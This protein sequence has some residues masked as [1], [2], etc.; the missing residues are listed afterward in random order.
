MDLLTNSHG[1]S[2]IALK[3]FKY[4]RQEDVFNCRKVC[5][6]WKSLIDSD[7]FWLRLHI[8]N[9]YQ[10]IQKSQV[11]TKY[12]YLP[13][14]RNVQGKP[15]SVMKIYPD[16]KGLFEEALNQN[17]K[18]TEELIPQLKYYYKN[19]AV[20]MQ[21]FQHPV[22]YAAQNGDM[23]LLK[24]LQDHCQADCNV[25]D[26]LRKCIPIHIACHYSHLHMVEYLLEHWTHLTN[27]AYF[28]STFI[29]ACEQHN[30]QIL[31]KLVEYAMDKHI[32]IDA[33]NI[34]GQKA[35]HAT[36]NARYIHHAELL[37]EYT[38]ELGLDVNE[39]D[40]S[41]HENTAFHYACSGP[42]ELVKL[43]VN[44]AERRGIDLNATNAFN[45][46][47]F[48]VACQEG[49]LEVVNY[50]LSQAS[51]LNIDLN[52]VDDGGKTAFMYACQAI[53]KVQKVNAFIKHSKHIQID[54]RQH[55][56][57][58]GSMSQEDLPMLIILLHN[59]KALNINVNAIDNAGDTHLHWTLKHLYDSCIDNVDATACLFLYHPDIDLNIRNND[60]KTPLDLAKRAGNNTLIDLINQRQQ[61]KELE[62]EIEGPS[63]AK[64][65]KLN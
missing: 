13:N 52:V 4:L 39:T 49:S 35:L 36:T 33:R 10:G 61:E 31:E 44:Q 56:V 27:K 18:V 9:I 25:K 32:R 1:L 53:D 37:L 26:K 59:S 23:V 63:I 48:I 60:G 40:L 2:W 34:N 38:Q 30:L 16:L 7:I 45:R 50:L 64:L 5:K 20:G 62:I 14:H 11:Y 8:A 46:T 47:G 15:E 17:R 28:K 57:L 58:S 6:L 65:P 54:N 24:L 55:K 43:F 22:H 51:A 12:M 3:I 21:R 41:E 19:T 29:I 42:L